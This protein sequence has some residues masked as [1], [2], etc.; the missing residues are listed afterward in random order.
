MPFHS[1][2]LC[3]LCQ[4]HMSISGGCCVINARPMPMCYV[5]LLYHTELELHTQ[6]RSRVN[7]DQL[8]SELTSAPLSTNTNT[9][10]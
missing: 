2:G 7:W 10:S 5:P 3:D 4:G 6:G 9:Q 8:F 1:D